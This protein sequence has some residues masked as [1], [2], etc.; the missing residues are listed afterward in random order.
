VKRTR[1][2]FVHIA[3]VKAIGGHGAKPSQHRFG[4]FDGCGAW[5]TF[6]GAGSAIFGGV[7]VASLAPTASEMDVNQTATFGLTWTV[8]TP[9]N[10]HH[11]SSIELRFRE[12]GSSALQLHWD[13]QSDAFTTV[14]S[15]GQLALVQ[16]KSLGSG[17]TGPSVTLTLPIHAHP[18]AAGH[19][20]AIEAAAH[21][22]AGATQD[23]E[24][25]GTLTVRMVASPQTSPAVL[26]PSSSSPAK[27]GSKSRRPN[28]NT[29]HHDDT[30]TEGQV[31][32]IR[33]DLAGPILV[34]AGADGP[35]EL[36]PR[37]EALQ[38]M[39]SVH[40][41]DYVSAEGEKQTEE[42]YDID[43]LEVEH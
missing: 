30:H 41:G 36:R 39:P 23:F 26:P 4:A 16:P 24:Q 9:H 2:C 32:A 43:E 3:I 40:V 37:G 18:S 20:F 22:D 38:V 7:G 33:S 19:T 28:N 31:M 10:W 25:V 6:S 5:P 15:T 12:S 14:A 1:C 34:I 11:L 13:E 17:P 27:E 29:G 35:I 21:D 8:P 42:Q